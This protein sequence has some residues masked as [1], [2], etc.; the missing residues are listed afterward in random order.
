MVEDRGEGQALEVI[1][2]G[3]QNDR[4]PLLFVHGSYCGAWIWN[5]F[6]LPELAKHGYWGAA[7]SLHG[8][9]ASPGGKDL[10][11]FAIADFVADIGYGAALFDE[12]PVIIGHSLGG[13]LAQKYALK[14]KVRGLVLMCA[15]SLLGLGGSGWH[16]AMSHSISMLSA[17]PS[18][19][20]ELAKLV[21]FGPQYVDQTVV[22]DAL[23][24]SHRAAQQV[25]HL[26]QPLQGE[27]SRV[28]FE[29]SM[30]DFARPVDPPPTLVIGGDNDQFVPK[31]DLDYEETCWG[32]ERVTI[33]GGPHGLMIDPLYWRE[34][35][36][37]MVLWL[38]RVAGPAPAM[39]AK[40]AGHSPK[41]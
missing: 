40:A 26:M 27:S 19:S 3:K 28:A 34:T 7:V 16:I 13:Y 18:L 24:S 39:S 33:K 2:F 37:S 32:G 8:H 9:G 15:P 41:P 6:F 5:V 1:R 23:F 29:A 38:D 10:S 36:D 30:P 4:P 11:K 25:A 22:L 20:G 14:N 21:A 31:S 12:P 17:G 35:L